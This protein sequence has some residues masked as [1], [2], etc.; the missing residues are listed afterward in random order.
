MQSPEF[1]SIIAVF[2]SWIVSYCARWQKTCPEFIS[3]TECSVFCRVRVFAQFF[4]ALLQ[5]WSFRPAGAS[6]SRK[7]SSWLRQ[8]PASSGLAIDCSDA[9]IYEIAIIKKRQRT[10]KTAPKRTFVTVF[11]RLFFLLFFLSIFLF[12][13]QKER[14]KK[15]IKK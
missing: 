9:V 4:A 7:N 8:A 12:L 5:S 6:R 11:S 1:K 10:K 15:G 13:S 14:E 3:G 2:P